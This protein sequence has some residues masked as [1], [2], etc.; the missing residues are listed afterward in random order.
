VVPVGC[1]IVLATFYLRF[2]YLVDI[3]A[4]MLCAPVAW[5]LG[6]WIERR[7]TA[8]SSAEELDFVEARSK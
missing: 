2:H 4:A 1:G 3:L 7:V 6:S 5:R 8:W